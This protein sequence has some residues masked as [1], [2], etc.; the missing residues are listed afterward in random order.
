MLSLS[1]SLGW[2]TVTDAGGRWAVGSRFDCLGGSGASEERRNR[3]WR[4]VA[5][6]GSIVGGWSARARGGARAGQWA[7]CLR[8]VGRFWGSMVRALV[9][10]RCG[11]RLAPRDVARHT[12]CCCEALMGRGSANCS[13][14][15]RNPVAGA[16]LASLFLSASRP[17]C[18]PGR[19]SSRLPPTQ[20]APQRPLLICLAESSAGL[21]VLLTRQPE[22]RDTQASL[23]VIPLGIRGATRH[24]DPKRHR[25]EGHRCGRLQT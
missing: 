18:S 16:G 14:D 19:Q 12:A 22:A 5:A 6:R 23:G 20:P 13:T 17:L 2:Q 15:T 3:K 4:R 8:Q 1:L 24:D 9:L 11:A 25:P 10:L 7:G 21:V